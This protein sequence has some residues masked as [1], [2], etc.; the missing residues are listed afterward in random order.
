MIGI[1]RFLSNRL[2][3]LSAGYILVFCSVAHYTQTTTLAEGA[4]TSVVALAFMGLIVYSSVAIRA[5]QADRWPNPPLLAALANCLIMTGLGFGGLFQ[6]LW[7]FSDFDRQVVENAVYS[8]F[9]TLIAAGIF[10]LI[11]TPNLFGRDVPTWS[12]IRLG[13]AWFIVIAV[14]LGLTYASPD[15]RWLADAVKPFLTGAWLRGWR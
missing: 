13:L 4:R 7:R 10:I 2:T 5:Y 11:T 12:Q 8:F 9:V 6:L 1:K 3:W 15:L 14:I